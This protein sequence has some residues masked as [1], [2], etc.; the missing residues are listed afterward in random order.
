M[1]CGRNAAFA[2][3]TEYFAMSFALFIAYILCSYLRPVELF[4]PDLGPYRPMLWL[5]AIAFL[6][7][8]G[9]ALSKGEFGARRVHLALLGA[10]VL[11]IALS[12]ITNQWVGGALTATLDFSTSAMLMVL[13]FL[14]LTTT[15]RLRTTCA[16]IAASVVMLAVLSVFSYHTGFMAEDLVLR[17]N[18]DSEENTDTGEESEIPV[19]DTSSKHILRIRSAGFLNDPNDF[20]QAMVMA[21]PLLLIGYV[22]RGRF[23]TLASIGVPGAILGYAIYLTQSRGALLGLASLALLPLHKW[24]GALRTGILL[25]LL[26]L[27]ALGAS[28]GGREFSSKESSA[29]ERIEAWSDGLGML[30]AKPL[31]GVGYGNFTE[32]RELTAHNS[33]VLCFAELGLFGYFAWLGMIMIAFKGLELVIRGAS[34][35]SAER[36]TALVLR[37]ALVG[38]LTCAWFLSRTYQPGLYILLALCVA[39]WYCDQEL[40]YRPNG[41]N[42]P[43]PTPPWTKSTVIAMVASIAA[44]YTFVVSHNLSR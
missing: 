34:R 22:R 43:D 15:R 30:R 12:Q 2:G 1:H 23:G 16:V 28:F 5:W 3:L 9:R 39:A 26:A 35:E 41:G 38:F 37:A 21:I 7:A 27:A 31:F 10:F 24:L 32:H 11:A 25:G 36:E 40:T 18:I 29:A 17:Q 42:A 33:F 19:H 4:A 14:N 44:V 6:T 8:L 20:A 13:C